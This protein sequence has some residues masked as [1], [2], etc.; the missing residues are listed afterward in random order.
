LSVIEN[1]AALDEMAADDRATP[2]AVA[3]G[4]VDKRVL[5]YAGN[6]G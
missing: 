2:L 5:L 6:M 4:M 1:W 3:Q